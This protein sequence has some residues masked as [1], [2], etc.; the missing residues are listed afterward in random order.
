MKKNSMEKEEL[1]EELEE[2][3]VWVMGDSEG[4]QAHAQLVEIVEQWY[5]YNSIRNHPDVKKLNADYFWGYEQ[6]RFDESMERVK[7]TVVR[8]EERDAKV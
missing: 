7:P 6:G 4:D 5:K 3:W 1:L 2:H 8:K